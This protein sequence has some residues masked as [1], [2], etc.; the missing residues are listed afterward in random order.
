MRGFCS[1]FPSSS[2][3]PPPFR[4]RVCV[5]DSISELCMR[6]CCAGLKGEKEEEDEG[7]SLPP[8]LS[9]LPKGRFPQKKGGRKTPLSLVERRR[10]KIAS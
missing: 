4:Y 7:V 1:S 6:V 2:L 5:C 3:P 9:S 10:G 8:L